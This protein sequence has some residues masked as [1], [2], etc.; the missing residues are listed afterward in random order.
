MSS[1]FV[2]SLAEKRDLYDFTCF[3]A[4]T[5]FS[6]CYRFACQYFPSDHTDSGTNISVYPEN[7]CR[8]CRCCVFWP[9]D[10]HENGRIYNRCLPKFK[11]ICRINDVTTN[12]SNECSYFSVNLCTNTCILCYGS[13]IF[14]SNDSK[15][16]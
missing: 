15:Y 10:A 16:I 2:L 8:S 3:R 13:I 1:E 4:L 11:C 14:I 6:S 9:L 12:K 7:C 5:Y